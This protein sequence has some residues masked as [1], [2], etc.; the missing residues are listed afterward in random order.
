MAIVCSLTVALICLL[1]VQWVS[2]YASH[3]ALQLVFMLKTDQAST[4]RLYYNA[5]QGF[6]DRHSETRSVLAGN[7]IERVAFA[8]PSSLQISRVKLGLGRASAAHITLKD[9][10]LEYG[11]RRLSVL[12]LFTRD[13]QYGLSAFDAS[14]GG[15]ELKTDTADAFIYSLDMARS[16]AQLEQNMAEDGWLAF[17]RVPLWGVGFAAGAG[18]VVYAVL[19]AGGLDWTC[20]LRGRRAS[21]ATAAVFLLLLYAPF[22]FNLL[23]RTDGLF[24]V[25]E[26]RILAQKPTIQGT[27]PAKFS[28]EMEVYF[29]DHFALRS[30]FIGWND[31]IRVKY[32][33]LSPISSIVVGKADWL[34]YAS[35]R[36]MEDYQELVRYSDAELQA[37]R[38]KLEERT[39][40]LRQQGT[41][42]L[43]MIVPDKQTVYPEYLPDTVRK[44]G[45]GE[46]TRTDQLVRYLKETEADVRVLDTRQTL[47]SR[48]ADRYLYYKADSH[49]NQYGALLAYRELI[50]EL[51]R[52]HPSL[53]VPSLDDYTIT[54]EESPDSPFSKD[55]ASLLGLASE[56]PDDFVRVK[57]KVPAQ[58]TK[59]LV[60]SKLFPRQD[61]LLAR[62]TG[63]AALPRLVMFRDSFGTA[64]VP[65]VAESFNRSLFVWSN[66]FHMGIVQEERP[67]IVVYEVVER[68]LPELAK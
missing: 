28:K 53:Q 10:V 14:P 21:A 63:N 16:F 57:R 24:I 59:A 18:G 54:V 60:T 58:A 31:Y 49:W 1:V 33:K 40:L 51:A 68:L 50:K 13:G 66:G 32:L 7:T 9:V 19:Y 56:F 55:I 22:L 64:L 20:R 23:W 38:V 2:V 4:Y 5:A 48:K 44:A 15:I 11:D 42:F 3:P 41:D 52:S 67:D 37:I 62:E 45:R 29:N 26:N 65:L 34:Y 30:L 25:N 12:S 39:R 17:K 43:L 47:L 35:D 36:S 27:D 6:N 46:G 61:V 8:L